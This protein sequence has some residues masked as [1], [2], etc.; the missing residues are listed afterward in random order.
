MAK[1]GAQRMA[2][3]RARIKASA[4]P[5]MVKAMLVAA[6]EH[7]YADALKR[8]PPNPP[9]SPNAALAYLCGGLDA[10]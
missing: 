1:T 9:K 5:E 10:A 7:G 3:Y 2:E 6:Y 8:L 4:E